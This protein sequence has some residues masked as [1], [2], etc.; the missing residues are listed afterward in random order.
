[1]GLGTTHD[2][3]GLLARPWSFFSGS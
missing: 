1:M 2:L 3:N